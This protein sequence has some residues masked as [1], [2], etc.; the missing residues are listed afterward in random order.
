MHEWS[1]PPAKKARTQIKTVIR[2]KA[3]TKPKASKSAT[4]KTPKPKKPSRPKKSLQASELDA[5]ERRRSGRSKTAIS[6]YAERD[7]KAD[8]DEM[9]E[10]VAQWDYGSDNEDDSGD[11]DQEG[12]DN[13]EE[14]E[15]SDASDDESLAHSDEDKGEEEGK[16][17]DDIDD[18]E[19]EEE[20]EKVERPKNN[21]KKTSTPS[22][23]GKPAARSAI[24]A[25][26]LAQMEKGTVRSTRGRRAA[27]DVSDMDVDDEDD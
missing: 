10:G 4:K 5:G 20:E 14:I 13:E 24:K 26:V 18:E 23:K 3:G 2:E 17:G 25:S 21:G 19:E 6:N 12:S 11:S 8:E 16:G 22:A 9:L 15:A 7:D 1:E 27:K